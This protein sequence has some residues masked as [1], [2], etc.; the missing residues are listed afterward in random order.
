MMNFRRALLLV[1][2]WIALLLLVAAVLPYL[3]VLQLMELWKLRSKW[4]WKCTGPPIV[5]RDPQ[6]VCVYTLR[7]L[8][9]VSTLPPKE[10]GCN[11]TDILIRVVDAVHAPWRSRFAL[12]RSASDLE[13]VNKYFES[14]DNSVRYAEHYRYD[15]YLYLSKSGKGY[16]SRAYGMLQIFALSHEYAL[17]MDFDAVFEPRVFVADHPLDVF[18]R[19]NKSLVLMAEMALCSCHFFLKN[20]H[21]GRCFAQ[22]WI[23]RCAT[24]GYCSR[25]KGKTIEDQIAYD[26]LIYEELVAHSDWALRLLLV[27]LA[28]R[29]CQGHPPCVL[30]R[31]SGASWGRYDSHRLLPTL[32]LPNIALLPANGTERHPQLSNTW[33]FRNL[34]YSGYHPAYIKHHGNWVYQDHVRPW[35]VRLRHTAHEVHALYARH[36]D[37]WSDGR[38]PAALDWRWLWFSVDRSRQHHLP[39]YEG[40]ATARQPELMK[41]TNPNLLGYVLQEHL[42]QRGLQIGLENGEFAFETLASWPHCQVYVIV[43]GSWE[44]RPRGPRPFCPTCPRVA[45]P[46]DWC[47]VP[48][49]LWPWRSRYRIVNG[50]VQE[51][52][53]TVADGSLDFVFITAPQEAEEELPL[54]PLLWAKLRRGGLLGGF[55]WMDCDESRRAKRLCTAAKARVRDVK[56]QVLQF[57]MNVSHKVAHTTDGAIFTWYLRK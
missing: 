54:L 3:P 52:L 48:K 2:C 15:H 10:R 4:R 25:D 9:G 53:R 51:H 56:T 8:I 19:S 29:E 38:W 57:A 16:T 37:A 24:K 46:Q 18:T 22:D 1:A 55:W 12:L 45:P 6:S 35:V 50:T 21:W 28:P 47:P 31:I 39:P 17:Y 49:L 14:M 43:P 33:S 7:E 44:R 41:V 36:K 42:G 27:W 26:L 32:E 40:N 11:G 30:D 20:D 34:P 13:Y 23:R 5:P